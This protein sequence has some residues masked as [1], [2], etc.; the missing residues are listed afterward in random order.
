MQLLH[1]EGRETHL[2][3]TFEKYIPFSFTLHH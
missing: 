2:N 1:S 3:V